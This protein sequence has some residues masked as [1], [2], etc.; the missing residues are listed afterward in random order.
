MDFSRLLIQGIE[1]IDSTNDFSNIISSFNQ[2]VIHT[3]NI[4]LVEDELYI[5]LYIDI[6]G[7]EKSA[8][9]IEIFNNKIGIICNRLKPY[10]ISAKRNEIYYGNYQR[11]ITLPIS[12]TDKSSV[13]TSLKN[14]VLKLTIDKEREEKN[15]F[16]VDIE[17]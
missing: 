12:V 8:I 5:Y 16:K 6:P 10:E 17:D 15:K 3:P 9:D 1:N 4:D 11:K 2:G 14:G 7:V 13:S